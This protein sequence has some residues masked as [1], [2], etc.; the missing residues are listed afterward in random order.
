M[1]WEAFLES[2]ENPKI[3]E[4]KNSLQGWSPAKFR[5]NYRAK[6]AVEA[7]SCIVL[8]DDDSRLT[9]EQVFEIWRQFAGVMYTSFSHTP[10]HPKHRIVLRCSRDLTGE[11]YE[12]VWTYVRDLSVKR[13]QILDESPKD[14]SRLWFVP[15]HRDGAPY[16]WRH[17]PGVVLDVDAI[18]AR[19]ERVCESLDWALDEYSNTLSKLAT[20]P[21]ARRTALATALGSAWPAKGR[22]EAQLAL[23]GALRAEGWA[24]EDALE[25]LCEVCRVAGNEDR[26]KRTKT[27]AHTWG[28]PQGSKL[29][30][31]TRLK[32][33]VDA[34]VVDAV[35]GGLGKEAE[36]VSRIGQPAER[37]S[38]L[39]AKDDTETLGLEY[40]IWDEE[41]LP[42]EFLVSGLLPRGAVGMFFGRADALKTWLLYSLAIAVASG[43][44]WL[45]FFQIPKALK[46]GIIDFETG[47]ANV[48]RRLFMLGAGKVKNLGRKSFAKVK[49]SDPKFWDLIRK[50]KLDLIIIDSLR[51]A[52]PGANENDSAEAILPL[53]LAAEFSELTRCAVLFIHHAKKDTADGWP[54]FRGSG[55]IEDQVDVAFAVR[56]TDVSAEHKT[57]DVRCVKPGDMRTP[58]AFS[59]DV[60]FDDKQRLVKLQYSK[61][62]PKDEDVST[63]QEIR[64][65]VFR[66]L[67][68]NPAGAPK[69]DLLNTLKVR[70]ETK[71]AVLSGMVLAGEVREFKQG[72][73]PFVM[74][75]PALQ[76]G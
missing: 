38:D 6:E 62:A 42:I 66:V 12:A 14:P 35:R 3:L 21:K 22:H 2:I 59:V 20:A 51:K 43:K 64:N 71:K 52:N 36:F 13:G 15:A 67:R 29:T 55:A 73:T 26:S 57:V 54:E 9:T 65:H 49:P 18:L 11:E 60:R 31:W 69:T 45:G 53:E 58:E 41:P 27:I 23:A 30:G 63:E 19:K 25:F 7:V 61:A 68:A 8:D 70:T 74:L 5:D 16:T 72:R 56:K 24:K 4:D 28:K 40:G 44:P 10:E 39:E 47:K 34:V 32:S 33:H 76:S 50:E 75:N 17:L 48:D 37:L 1:D 46:V